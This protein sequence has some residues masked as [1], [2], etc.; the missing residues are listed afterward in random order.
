[1]YLGLISCFEIFLNGEFSKALININNLIQTLNR[2]KMDTFFQPISDACYHVVYATKVYIK[3]F[4]LD[5]D[6]EQ[7]ILI[8]N[9]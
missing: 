6:V 4:N 2:T 3:A 8:L 1:M 5:E 7:V 9:H